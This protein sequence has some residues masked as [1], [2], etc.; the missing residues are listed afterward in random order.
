MLTDI[1]FVRFAGNET[2]YLPSVQRRLLLFAHSVFAEVRDESSSKTNVLEGICDQKE[3][4][5]KL[6]GDPSIGFY[7]M[8]YAVPRSHE[9]FTPYALK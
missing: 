2:N 7:Y 9:L 5:T 1:I 6:R 8:V 3:V 4:M